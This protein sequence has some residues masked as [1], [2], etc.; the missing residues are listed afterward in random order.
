[1]QALGDN[2]EGFDDSGDDAALNVLD[3]EARRMALDG[4]AVSGKAWAWERSL[5]VERTHRSARGGR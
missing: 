2:P 4:L 1:V 5:S 3:T